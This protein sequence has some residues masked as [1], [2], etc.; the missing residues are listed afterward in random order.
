MVQQDTKQQSN[1]ERW[2]TE[3]RIRITASVV[4]GIAKMQKRTKR[5]TRVKNMLYSNFRGSDATRYGT[6]ME[7]KTREHYIQHQQLNGHPNL[8]TTSSGLVIAQEDPWLAASPDDLVYDPTASPPNG[9]A[10]YKNPYTSR[11]LTIA[12]ACGTQKGFCLYTDEN[13][14]IHLK[15]NHGYYY[16]IQCQM[17]CVNVEWCDFVVHTEKDIH[18]E[19]ISR[20][21][22]W[23]DKQL[24][25]LKAFY[26]EALLPELAC[27]RH[28]KGGIREPDHQN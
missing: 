19:R 3:R 28:G 4:G 27:P 24:L 6:L 15:T 26:F 7:D 13:S 11:N 23:W 21:H 22:Q 9:L 25:K 8:S 2:M 12:E 18:I 10:E 17:Y 1:S 16:Q 20:N 5:S 14:S